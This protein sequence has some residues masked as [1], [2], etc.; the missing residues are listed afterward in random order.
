MIAEKAIPYLPRGVRL[1]FDR[2]R[3]KWVLLAPERAVALDAVGHAVLSEIDGARS[4]GEVVSG[5]AEKY[6]A[7]REQIAKDS[8]QFLQGLLNRRFLELAP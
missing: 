5:L 4:Y 8:A 6:A 7:P 3:E 2:V 1:H